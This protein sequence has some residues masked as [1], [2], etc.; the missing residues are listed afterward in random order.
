MDGKA[1]LYLDDYHEEL[2]GLPS[3]DVMQ[4]K[5]YLSKFEYATAREALLVLSA[6]NGIIFSSDATEGGF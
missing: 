3:I 1:E 2:A 5:A 4:I 6:R